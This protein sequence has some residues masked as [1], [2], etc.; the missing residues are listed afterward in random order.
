[1]AELYRCDTADFN[2]LY[3][4]VTT[5]NPAYRPIE[6]TNFNGGDVVF[7]AYTGFLPETHTENAWYPVYQPEITFSR[8]HS[9]THWLV[10]TRDDTHRLND[11]D[12]DTNDRLIPNEPLNDRLDTLQHLLEN[13][14]KHATIE[15]MYFHYENSSGS[16]PQDT[17]SDL[18][19]D[20]PEHTTFYDLHYQLNANDPYS[21]TPL[22]KTQLDAIAHQGAY[23]TTFEQD[24]KHEHARSRCVCPNCTTTFHAPY[25]HDINHDR[26]ALANTI[27]CPHCWHDTIP[28]THIND[29]YYPYRDDE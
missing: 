15:R 21:D 6:L 26:Y 16:V 11:A 19:R 28:A 7:R 2:T 12:P 8:N 14:F 10:G 18:V 1:M 23:H 3:S 25:R 17:I 4:L 9:D 13:N 27:Y 22:A 5:L 24:D 29:P 20:A